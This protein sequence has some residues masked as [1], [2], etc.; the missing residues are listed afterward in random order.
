MNKVFTLRVYGSSARVYLSTYSTVHPGSL[1][2]SKNGKEVFSKCSLLG[3]LLEGLHLDNN[4]IEYIA[5]YR[6]FRGL[7][8]IR[9]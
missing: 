2:A 1:G 8:P 9:T 3:R 7:V 5:C 6:C 4:I